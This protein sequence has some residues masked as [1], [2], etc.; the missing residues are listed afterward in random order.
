[1]ETIPILLRLRMLD[2]LPSQPPEPDITIL[3]GLPS[4][5]EVTNGVVLETRTYVTEVR[6]ETTD[7]K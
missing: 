2:S 5:V 4:V 1:M 7:D 6:R 3:E